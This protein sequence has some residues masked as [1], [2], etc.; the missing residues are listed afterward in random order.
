MMKII[1]Y[2]EDC[3]LFKKNYSIIKFYFKIFNSMKKFKYI[4]DNRNII[5]I[6][7]INDKTIEK[8]END[9]CNQYYTISNQN[10]N[11]I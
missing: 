6:K 5:F 2:D 10:S 3:K 9:L 4:K 11:K 7:K 8:K 1:N